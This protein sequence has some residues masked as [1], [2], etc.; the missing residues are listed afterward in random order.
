MV[1]PIH[2]DHMSY[3]YSPLDVAVDIWNSRYEDPDWKQNS[4]I[5]KIIDDMKNSLGKK[6]SLT[7][8]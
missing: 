6:G 8:P 5:N 1:V 4:I 7:T 2:I 3:A